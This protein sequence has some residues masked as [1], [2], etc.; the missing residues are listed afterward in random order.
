MKLPSWVRSCAVLTL[1]WILAAVS[2]R[3]W[4]AADHSVPAW[5]QADYLTGSLNYWHI[6]QSPDW[7]SS[8]WWTAFWE[9][10]PK[11][12]PLTY[13]FTI[14][15]LSGFGLG[16]DP[17][18]LV[19]LVFSAIL[20]GSVYVL[21]A[22]LLNPTVGL[23]AAGLCVLFPGLYVYR[24]QYLLDYP[25]TAMVVLSFCCL[26]GWREWRIQNRRDVNRKHS[27]QVTGDTASYFWAVAYGLSLGLAI[28]T[29]QTAVFFLCIPTLWVMVETFREKAWGRFLQLGFAGILSIL[30]ISPWV[31]TNW[32]LIFTS[33]KRATVD[34]AIAEG[35]PSLLSL[36][37]WTYY[38]RQLPDQVSWP[39][40][41]VPLVGVW[42]Y[43]LKRGLRQPLNNSPESLWQSGLTWLAIFWVSGYLLCSLNVNKDPRYSLPLLPVF[44]IFLAYGLTFWPRYFRQQIGEAVRWGV[45][46]LAAAVMLIQLW[47]IGGVAKSVARS[48]SPAGK[49]R[50]YLGQ[51]WPHAEVIDTI[52]QTEPFL[53]SN[54][55]VLPSTSEINQHNLNYF[56]A[57]RDLQV[58]GRQVGT[59]LEHIPQ[60]SLSLSWFVT[61]SETQGSVNRIAAAQ[62][63]MVQEVEQSPQFQRLKSWPLPDDSQLNLYHRQLPYIEVTPQVDNGN[64]TNVSDQVTLTSVM[65]PKTSPPG[66]SIPVVYTWTGSWDALQS[67]LI[68]LTWKQVD[69]AQ[70]EPQSSWIHDHAVAMGTLHSGNRSEAERTQ[71]FQVIDRM[72][73][74]P[75][76]ALQ[77]GQYELTA[78]YLNPETGKTYPISAPPIDLKIDPKATPF[79]SP[80]LDLV[81]QL[82]QLAANLPQGMTALEN[83]FDEIGRINQYD[84]TQSYTIQAEQSLAYRLQQN[85]Q[86]PNHLEWAYGLAFAQVLQQDSREAV[87]ALQRV[88][89]LDAQN[90]FAWAYLSFVYLYHWQPKAAEAAIQKAIELQPDQVE[91]QALRGIANLLQGNVV[92]AWQDLRQLS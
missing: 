43:F 1:I 50:V 31:R 71:S 85:P 41:L 51:P 25:L 36:N 40:L 53:E 27:A 88:T 30:V 82:R 14:P 17:A 55:G 45:V 49:H 70:N 24:L 59:R 47:P 23:W 18:N 11:T 3:L 77:P 26:T 7:F 46:G 54:L 78:T 48:L 61:K 42:L 91:F 22:K 39:L 38:W 68:L 73:M 69:A 44:S 84:P 19:H 72:G 90:S 21:G 64:K 13:F 66:Q 28:L 62:T 74:F 76:E 4:F 86:D 33:G 56:G 2:D 29:K 10:S 20:L 35:D 12:P 16:S 87:T 58:F 92:G 63:A 65:V 34:S 67:G 81:T 60:D 5:D 37:A 89:E 9:L 79:P 15:F 32:L 80:E 57:I 6:L 8:D 52:I 83:V 75:G